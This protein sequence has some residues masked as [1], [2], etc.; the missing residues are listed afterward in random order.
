MP[1]KP[2]ASARITIRNNKTGRTVKSRGKAKIFVDSG[3][4]ISIIPSRHIPALQTTGGF[5]VARARIQTANGV[6]ETTALKDVS[7]CLD[8]VCFRGDIVVIEDVP[9]DIL[10]G[11]DFLQSAKCKIDFSK[12]TLECGGRKLSFSLDEKHG[13]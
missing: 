7:L 10:I 4:S 6:R 8:K 12:K 1:N 2:F 13:S 5:D 9:G 11:T 3:A